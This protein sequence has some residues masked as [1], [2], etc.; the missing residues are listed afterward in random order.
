MKQFQENSERSRGL[1][2]EKERVK[3]LSQMWEAA[4]ENKP[5]A[6]EIGEIMEKDPTIKLEHEERLKKGKGKG[7][8]EQRPSTPRKTITDPERLREAHVEIL[9]LHVIRWVEENIYT[10]HAEHLCNHAETIYKIAEA[11]F[12]EKN[13]EKRINLRK[14]MHDTDETW[15]MNGL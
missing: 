2:T 4:K 12:K 11:I 14:G 5:I 3:A 9:G 10:K 15:R 8:T 1:P 6:R 7:K 13:A